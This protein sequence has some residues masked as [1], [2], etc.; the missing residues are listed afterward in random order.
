MSELYSPHARTRARA[1]YEYVI[2]LQL[3]WLAHLGLRA[4]VEAGLRGSHGTFV[5]LSSVVCAAAAVAL[6]QRIL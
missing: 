2:P 6:G 5:V 3:P 4:P 1:I